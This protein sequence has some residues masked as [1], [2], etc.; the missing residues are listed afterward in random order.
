MGSADG[1]RG[2]AIDA[3]YRT[4]LASTLRR[5]IDTDFGGNQT[6]AGKEMHISQGQISQM[7]MGPRGIKG[8]GL[9]SLLRLREYSGMSLD[10]LLGLEPI[11]RDQA[12]LERLARLEENV[13]A[14]H[15]DNNGDE[16]RPRRS[17]ISR[18]R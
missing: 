11:S 12:I 13:A 16:P 15:A 14:L 6:A 5:I 9:G 3:R 18:R 17:T 2:R 8:V 4:H 7:L 10:E 1:T